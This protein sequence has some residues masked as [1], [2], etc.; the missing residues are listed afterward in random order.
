VK[1]VVI[2]AILIWVGGCGA[3]VAAIGSSDPAAV[4]TPS[5]AAPAPTTA[6]SSPSPAAQRYETVTAPRDAAEAAGYPCPN[7][8]RW[9]PKKDGPEYAK[10]SGACSD[11]DFFSIYAERCRA[12]QT[13]PH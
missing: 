1:I 8:E 10:E 7:W 3:I 6:A 13:G 4:P 9:N 2:A 5:S 12:C 11:L